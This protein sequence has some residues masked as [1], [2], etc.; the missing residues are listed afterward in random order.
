MES[1]MKE[2]RRRLAFKLAAMLIAVAIA[3]NWL[4]SGGTDKLADWSSSPQERE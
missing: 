1:G 2:S 3:V 4:N